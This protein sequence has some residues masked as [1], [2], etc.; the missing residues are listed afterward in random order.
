MSTIKDIA[1]KA[2]VSHGTVSNVLNKNGNVSAEKIQLVKKAAEELGY[3][4]NVQ[5]QQLRRGNTKKVCVIVP[6]IN[7]RSY[8][9]LYSGIEQ[10]LQS[11][12]YSVDISCT[13]NMV[14]L[15]EKVVKKALSSNPAAVVV[16]SSLLKDKGTFVSDSP[17]IFVERRVE[18]M[19]RNSIFASFDF[20]KAG[21]E[22]ALKCV[23]DGHKNIALFCENKKYSNN[24]DFING[25]IEILDNAGCFYKM[26]LSDDSMWFSKAFDI[27]HDT[28]NFDAVIVMSKEDA[29]YLK[30]AHEYNPKSKLPAIYALMSKNIGLEAEVEKYELNYKLM[31]RNIAE[32]ILLLEEE[33]PLEEQ[34]KLVTKSIM[35]ENDGFYFRNNKT[36]T[37][38][39]EKSINFLCIKNSTSKAIRMLLPSFKE[40]TGIKVNLI[41]VPYD[42]LYKTAKKCGDN[43]PYDLIRI[44]MAWMTEIGKELF[45]EL[46]I[47]NTEI[48][49]IWNQ[50]TGN[51]PDDYYRVNDKYLAMPF[52]A[53]VQMM[54][55]RKDL[56][57]DELI[58][59][60][61]FEKN[62]RKL[63]VPKT[64]EE[65]NEVARFFTRKY[66]E[67]S[68]TKYGTS[69]TFGRTFLAACDMLPRYREYQESIFDE[70]G[71]VII[72]TPSMKKAINNYIEACKYT[73]N[74]VYQW[75]GDS[76]LLFSEGNTAMHIVFSN[77]AS[78][79]IHNPDSK[80]IGKIAFDRVPGGN[81]LLG[82][83]AIGI[84]KYSKNYEECI[85]FLQWIYKKD[86]A[87]TITY[88]GGYICNKDLSNNIDILELYPWIEGMEK[89]FEIGWR[90][91]KNQ[92]NNKFEEFRFEDILGSLIRLIA[93]GI[94]DV[95]SALREA[96]I[97]CDKE[98]N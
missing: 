51:L 49:E 33:A 93:S 97:V 29:D 19:P 86:I 4:I 66:N 15:E 63:E 23:E 65:F 35:V 95:D 24:K 90:M 67:H 70:N 89:S 43:S 11:K 21:S 72:Q 64:F 54:F 26:F 88:L 41:E 1:V 40:M 16:V 91:K 80:V 82:G 92:K 87:A 75:W 44:D 10:T 52:D 50:I 37:F 38:I 69:A 34:P 56:F 83:G 6:K 61:F 32:Y 58:K 13:N 7:L 62:K 5:A 8:N 9:D 31:G 57:E 74:E 20:N 77:Y 48:Q 36:E 79:M 25:M 84:S 73:N 85:K 2:G 94:E 17:F 39:E 53:C 60:E 22:I 76:S 42:E 14:Y 68:A 27:L 45:E 96:Q 59:R 81:P 30:I 78:D 71:R 28:E 98:F 12:D 55:Y 46:N 47:N 18:N 3:K